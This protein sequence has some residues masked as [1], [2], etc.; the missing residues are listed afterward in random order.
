[1]RLALRAVV[2]AER[3]RLEGFWVWEGT[4]GGGRESASGAVLDRGAP[5]GAAPDGAASS[6]K[7]LQA[8]VGVPAE[9][10]LPEVSGLPSSRSR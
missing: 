4:A 1:M 5:E 9:P 7:L 2:K 8:M 3:G 6:G 10:E